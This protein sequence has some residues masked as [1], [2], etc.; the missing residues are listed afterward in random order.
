[1]KK[2]LIILLGP[3]IILSMSEKNAMA[4]PLNKAMKKAIQGK[5]NEHVKIFDHDFNVKKASIKKVGSKT[6][7]T[8]QISHRLRWRPD[9]QLYY[10]IV[11]ENGVIKEIKYSVN[12]GGL[13][14]LAAPFVS[15]LGTYYTG[16]PIPPD[17][18]ESFG[19]SLGKF[20]EG[21]WE[22]VAQFIVTNIALRVK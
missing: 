21:D 9:D 5:G 18:I 6:F 7:I 20:V 19:R 16:V 3:I 4:D 12:R 17:K 11:K 22:K 8:G 13:S 10:T 14:G 15:A 1:M 2:L